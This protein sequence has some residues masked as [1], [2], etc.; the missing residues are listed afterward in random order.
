LVELGLYEGWLPFD[1]WSRLRSREDILATGDLSL[2]RWEYLVAYRLLPDGDVLGAPVP[3]RAGA[4][5]VRRREVLDLLGFAVVAGALLSLLLA[6]LVART[7]TRPIHTLQVAS[8]RVGSGNLG[9]RLSSSRPDEF[10][11][12]FSS[13]NRMVRRLRRARRDLVRTTRRTQAIV[14]DAATGVVALDPSGRVTL[15]NARAEELL[16]ADVEV[17]RRLRERGVAAD[18]LVRWV[19]L[20]FRDGLREAGTEFQFGDRRVRIRARRISREGPLGGAVLSLEDVTDE[21]RTERILAWGEMARQVAHEVKNPL[22]PIKLSIQ[23][24]RRAFEDR[25]PDFGDILGRN[26]D[27]ALREIDRL[28][29]IASSFSR[30]GAPAAADEGPLQAVDLRAVVTEVLAL[31]ASGEG[32]IRFELDI[33]GDLPA[34]AARS[35]EL[36]EVLVNLLENARSAIEERGCVSVAAEPTPE[37]VLLRVEDDGSGIPEE[38]LP[39]VFEPHF[40]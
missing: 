14:E 3:H 32:A 2:G 4:T 23:H 15:A 18:E 12:V 25:R 1:V 21:L 9:V 31:Y 13:F 19:Q 27:A 6:L 35:T 29:T 39:R 16:G 34:V 33:P 11:S 36:K 10:G 20:Y 30:F 24:I 26:A 7:L 40:S 38:L 8:E 22:T 17:G 28:A 37:A 5:A